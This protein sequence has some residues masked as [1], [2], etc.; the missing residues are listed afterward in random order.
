MR[1]YIC[2]FVQQNVNVCRLSRVE[3]S[4]VMSKFYIS[5]KLSIF[6]HILPL[7]MGTI[8]RLIKKSY[9]EPKSSILDANEAVLIAKFSQTVL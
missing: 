4:K 9:F 8:N 6:D 2:R 1:N 3:L 7:E 5:T